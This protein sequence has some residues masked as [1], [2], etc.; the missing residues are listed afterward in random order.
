MLELLACPA[1]EGA[2]SEEWSCRGCGARYEA[3]DGIPNLRVASGPRTEAVRRF[4]EQAPFPGY[5]PRDSLEWLR[6]RAE[7][8]AFARLLDRAIPHD[9]RV[10]DLGCGTGQ[11]SLYLARPGR[12]VIAAD[13]TRA[14]LRLGAAAARRFGLEGVQFIETD[15]HKPGLRRDSFDVVYSSGV[16]HHTPDPRSAF[17][18]LAKLARP[19][20]MIVLGLYN[21]FAR[22][23]LRLR[24]LIARMSGYR[25]IVFDPVLRDRTDEPARREAWVRDQYQHPEEHRHTIAQVQRWFAANGV[26]Y[27]RA[28]PSAMLG[29]DSDELFEREADSWRVEGWLAQLGWMRTLAH[30]GGLFIMIGQ[31]AFS[32]RSCSTT[33]TMSPI[34][35]GPH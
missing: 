28:Y 34:S 16:L 12:V 26:E 11:M 29:T 23:P 21:A 32:S 17:A 5:P 13:L 33:S 8:S 31:R 18:R 14:S 9:A 35:S 20:G 7:R 22:I 2:L 4:Y 15:L 24:R 3:P 19:G 6:A 27:V 30:E 10:L 1:C 25:W